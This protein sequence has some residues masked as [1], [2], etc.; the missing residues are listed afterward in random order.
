[1]RGTVKSNGPAATAATAPVPPNV[2][3]PQP[4]QLAGALSDG[5]PDSTRLE[6]R[7][8]K[9]RTVPLHS[10]VGIELSSVGVKCVALMC[11]IWS[12]TFPES[13]PPRPQSVASQS[14]GLLP[15][16]H[17]SEFGCSK[18]GVR[19]RGCVHVSGERQCY[20]AHSSN[21]HDLRDSQGMASWSWLAS[22]LADRSCRT[23]R[24]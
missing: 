18:T 4:V 14:S 8:P 12:S 23:E 17:N 20:G 11:T 3:Q 2:R 19:E 16:N 10:P 9:L 7:Q 5:T 21:M 24:V 15:T 6:P 13:C 1:M 22:Q